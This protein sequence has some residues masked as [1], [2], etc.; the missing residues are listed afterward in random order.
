MHDARIRTDLDGSG[1]LARMPAA[2]QSLHQGLMSPYEPTVACHKSS[3]DHPRVGQHLKCKAALGQLTRLLHAMC[4]PYIGR[5]VDR[6]GG[7]TASGPLL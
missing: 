6:G 3:E 5:P 1:L 2:L 7:S 4:V